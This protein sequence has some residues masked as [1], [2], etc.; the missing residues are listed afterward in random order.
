MSRSSKYAK[1]LHSHVASF[2]KIPLRSARHPFPQEAQNAGRYRYNG[3]INQ[4]IPARDGSSTSRAGSPGPGSAKP[5]RI[6]PHGRRQ[7]LQEPSLLTQ[8]IDIA[9]RHLPAILDES[10]GG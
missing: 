8:A 9:S 4:V 5:T 2:V 10:S 7:S 6:S 1:Y 3:V